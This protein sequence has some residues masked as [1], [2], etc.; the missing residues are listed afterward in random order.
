MNFKYRTET[1]RK[2]IKNK[3]PVKRERWRRDNLGVWD[4]HTHT[5]IYRTDK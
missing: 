5:T 3:L 2:D 1:D 4:Q